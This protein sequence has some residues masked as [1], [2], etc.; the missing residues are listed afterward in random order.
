LYGF[1]LLLQMSESMRSL[2]YLDKF[3]KLLV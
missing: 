3:P 2:S 1:F